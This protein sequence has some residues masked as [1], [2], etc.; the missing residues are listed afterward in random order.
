LWGAWKNGQVPGPEAFGG[1]YHG[2]Y[3]PFGGNPGSGAFPY[4]GSGPQPMPPSFPTETAPPPLRST[5][6][7]QQ[8][9]YTPYYYN[10]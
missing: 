2:G 8:A 3:I 10:P 9:Y 5:S 4:F 6:T 7:S 1:G